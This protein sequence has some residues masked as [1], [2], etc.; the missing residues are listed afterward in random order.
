M[1]PTCPGPTLGVVGG[2]QLGRML[3]EA[4]SPLGVDVVVLDPT[5]NCPASRVAE[6][7]EGA[8][9]DPDAVRELADR[10]DAL[11]L[12][13]E[14]ADPDVLEE[15]G[16][17]YDVPVNPS[18]DALR[19]IQDKLVQKRAF[20]DA[21]IPVPEF[22]AVDDADDLAD[23]VDR[24]G[25][26]ML[27]ARTGGYDGRGNLPVEPGDD[28][29]AKLAAVGAGEGGA[30]AEELIDFEREL[31]VVAVRGD[32]ERRAFPVV[33]N[34]HREEILRETVAP[35]RCSD[36]VAERARE[37]ALDTLETLDGRGVFAMEL[38]EV[39][40]ARSASETSSGERSDPRDRG[41]GVLVN[42]VA[43]R[44][45]NSGHWSIEGATTSQFEQH[46]RAALG[47]PLG[48]A[49]ARAPTVMANVLGDVPEPRPASLS[50]V[51]DVLAA[52]NA[53]LHWY[54]KREARPLRK[55]GHLTLVDADGDAAADGTAARDDLLARARDL[56]DG[57][58]FE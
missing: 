27:K 39:S 9:D 25:G 17:E 4:A 7:I 28:Y 3:A 42:E 6:Q 52:P 1:T 10:A 22:V 45:H 44:P 57:L 8:F 47:W 56:R 58:T 23:A 5:P 13:I 36:A 20:A 12:E 55:M 35:A 43:P 26:C 19:T 33:E 29:E 46:V 18:P 32:D 15:I 34:V 40:E 37:V 11:T 2:G 41:G 48:T 21:G 14:L 16:E 31:S 50:G 30:M 53:N 24:F 49:E 38:F 51:G 54:G